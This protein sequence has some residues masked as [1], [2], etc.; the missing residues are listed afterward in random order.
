MISIIIPAFN[1]KTL[2]RAIESILH[3]ALTSLEIIIIDD[4]RDDKIK[5]FIK[6]QQYSDVR[7]YK[8]P[9]NIGTTLSRKKGIRLAKGKYIG[10]LDDDDIMIN[11]N[12]QVLK[13]ELEE[14][15]ADFI[16]CN[17][18]ID[19]QVQ[20]SRRKITLKPYGEDFKANIVSQL[21]PFLQCC[22]FQKQVLIDAVDSL[23]PKAEPSEDW[24]F[25]IELSKKNLIIKHCEFFGF[26]WNLSNTSQS[27]NYKKE[28]LALQYIIHKHNNYMKLNSLKLLSLQYRKLGCMQYYFNNTKQAKI[29]FKKA[30][31]LY[32][33]SIKNICLKIT[34]TLP[35]K[36]Y[37]WLM[38]KY[39]QK[40]T[41]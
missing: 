19:N 10:F 30:F 3:Q 24:D 7:Y 20:N 39:V 26:Q 35:E 40:I 8:N 21:G 2:Q 32:P 33:H 27:L 11:N 23:D 6:Q 5:N 13:K 25:F 17:Y 22:L 36:I 12:L 1:Y 38:T 31:T 37:H 4:S 16:F 34:I 15:Y 28:M 41:S 18:I 9:A 29:A 14:Q